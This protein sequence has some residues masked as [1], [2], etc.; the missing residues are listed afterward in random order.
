MSD[1]TST[2]FGQAAALYDQSRPSYPPELLNRVLE[3]ADG[4]VVDCGAGTGLLTRVLLGLGHEVVAVEPDPLMRQQLRRAS[5]QLTVF[6]GSAESMPLPD[7]SA[8]AVVFGQAWHWVD[9]TAA[10][11]E[12]D[13]ILTSGGCLILVWNIRNEEAGW[14]RALTEVMGRSPAESLILGPGPAVAA[15]FR[16][17]R[18]ETADW[19]RV[20]TP[21]TIR[22]L[23]R[24][25]SPYLNAIPA[26]QRRV[27]A[28][29]DRLLAEHPAIQGKMQ[30]A[31]PY[32]TYAFRY[33]R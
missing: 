28:A 19:D 13:R 25:R 15:P 7:A 23:V 11:R 33:T 1:H 9:V 20:V 4:P 18:L 30:F 12:A 5:P 17:D 26:E 32:R 24:S 29:V 27:D 16:L 3:T 6:E 22:G 31:L 21:E 2:S 10:S 14:V 8:R